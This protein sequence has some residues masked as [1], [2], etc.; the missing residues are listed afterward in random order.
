M[1]CHS[2][3]LIAALASVALLAAAAPT[4]A[5]TSGDDTPA[6]VT[7]TPDQRHLLV[8]KQLGEERW[9]ISVNLVPEAETG[10]GP[11]VASIAGN[12]FRPGSD[13]VSFL[14]CQAEPGSTRSL[15]DPEG[16]LRLRCKG[17]GRCAEGAPACEGRSSCGALDC[18]RH[19]WTL[20][21]S[22]LEVP[23]GFFLPPEGLSGGAP[24]PAAAARAGR[25]GDD[26]ARL[27]SG[28]A[29]WLADRAT[30]TLP[31]EASAQ[32]AP[33]AAATMTID[34]LHHLVVRDRSGQ[35]WSIVLNMVPDVRA[36]GGYRIATVTGNVYT[37]T[38]PPSFVFCEPHVDEG[39]DPAAAPLLTVE[40]PGATLMFDCQAA[41]ACATSA[42]ACAETDWVA[43]SD[44]ITLE[45]RFFLPE[46]GRGSPPTSNRRMHVYGPEGRVPAIA[47]LEFHLVD[48]D[49]GKPATCDDGAPCIVSRIGL[50]EEV[51]GRQIMIGNR[52]C[53]YVDPV[54]PHCVRCGTKDGA[55]IPAACGEPCSF[56]VGQPLDANGQQT[57][58]LLRARGVCLP[59]DADSPHCFCHAIEARGARAVQACGEVEGTGCA[60]GGCC[61]DDPRDGCRPL[62]G[63]VS[64]PG[65]C[66]GGV[67]GASADG[68]CGTRTAGA[69]ICGDGAVTGS[70]LC[71]PA[72]PTAGALSCE[73]LGLPAGDLQCVGCKIEG[74]GSSGSARQ[75]ELLPPSVLPKY[76][77]A[78]IRARWA[79]EDGDIESLVLIVGDGSE[80]AWSIPD[81]AGRRRGEFE[82]SVGCNEDASLIDFRVYLRDAA[83]NRSE[84]QELTVPCDQGA[85]L[86][87][88]G[89]RAE[90]EVCDSSAPEGSGCPAGALCANDCSACNPVDSCRGRCCPSPGTFCAPPDQPCACDPGC[91]F[92]NECCADSRSECGF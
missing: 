38:Q 3:L 61:I 90:G 70:E 6:G 8:N 65:M 31:G 2:S 59:L 83:D 69:Q 89:V 28:A 80:R 17:T 57:G 15:S 29:R 39:V 22:G 27:L 74:C 78:P 54:T 60:G 71:D 88:D 55:R 4:R 85:P 34:Q 66:V 68:A 91:L 32:S 19:G 13:E 20:V 56:D 35:R 81:A 63:D 82:F 30:A 44:P 50:C 46:G 67:D 62:D 75:L 14:F 87:G 33:V 49:G 18:A 43:I 42:F 40:R 77:R 52:C 41:S 37:E 1:R 12:V 36:P 11:R 26:L 92:R 23:A 72:D 45:A 21:A 84:T 10:S 48:D 25:W 79:D 24:E 53:C 9:T 51:P 73:L 64:C 47:S 76:G 16:V 58:I 5:Q 7:M 86:C